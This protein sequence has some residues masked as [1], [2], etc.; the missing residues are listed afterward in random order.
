MGQQHIQ[1]SGSDSRMALSAATVR[2]WGWMLHMGRW[3]LWG[4]LFDEMEGR[5]DEI[6]GRLKEIL[7]RLSVLLY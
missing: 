1:T 3:R 5:E 6:S 2:V 4:R 7:D